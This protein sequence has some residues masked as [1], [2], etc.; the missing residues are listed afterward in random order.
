MGW[1]VLRESVR[2]FALNRH[3]ERAATLSF[4]AFFA[5]IPM[6]LI[7]VFLLANLI[8]SSDAALAVIE[9][10]AAGIAPQFSGLI[11]R[12]VAVVARQRAWT[13]LSMVLL[14]WSATP[15]TAAIRR[16]F[17]VVFQPPQRGSIIRAKLRDAVAVLTLLTGLLLVIGGQTLVGVWIKSEVL[18]RAV[19]LTVRMVVAATSIGIIYLALAP[20]RLNR[21]LVTLAAVLST[22]LVCAVGPLFGMLLRF[23]PNYGLAFGSLKALFLMLVA[24][25]YAF[26]AML[27]VAEVVANLRRRE[28]L[29]LKELFLRPEA[30]RRNVLLER[31]LRQYQ[32]GEKIFEEGAAG[33]EMFWIVEGSVRLQRIGRELRELQPGEYFGEMAML[34]GTPRTATAIA[35]QAGAVLAAISE[36]NLA[37]VLRENPTI[38]LAT[39]KEMAL[40]LKATDERFAG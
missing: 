39:L 29:V 25:Q 1:L 37:V 19:T 21:G 30:Q 15:F 32:P 12:E 20:V 9:R 10:A 5:L 13:A 27:F 33:R 26:S 14:F 22:L 2:S 40:R 38:V 35:G 31:F 36:E 16:G 28:A 24:V 7:A 23:N 8:K 11:V 17:A 18:A 3:F 34:I 4:Y 6:L